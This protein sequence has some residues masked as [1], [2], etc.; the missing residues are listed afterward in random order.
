M[1]L[2]YIC[3]RYI[4]PYEVLELIEPIVYWLALPPI[5][6]GVY[7]V[8]HVSQLRKC[9]AGPNA[10]LETNQPEVQPNLTKL[11]RPVK[12]LD[13]TEKTFRRKIISVVKVLW[14]DQT[15]HKGTWKLRNP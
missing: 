12:I 11:K 9:I 13:Q 6:S 10:I 4:G 5:L 2:T 15:E 8:F 14:S 7:N 3:F 1:W